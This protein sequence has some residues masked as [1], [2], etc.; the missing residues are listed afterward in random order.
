M[1]M[2]Q[3]VQI[4]KSAD[5]RA[6]FGNGVEGLIAEYAANKAKADELTARNQEIA[7]EL[8]KNAAFKPGAS[9]GHLVGA[10]LKVTITRRVN[11]RWINDRLETARRLLTDELFFRVFKWKYEPR[12][13]KDVD[14]F[15]E[16][17]APEYRSAIL[18]AMETTPGNPGVKLEAIQ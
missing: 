15:L 11:T 12:S 5:P 8:E 9:T 18:A 13:K 10:G 7:L 2:T 1:S 17:A 4:G 16:Y 14:A 6:A 3:N